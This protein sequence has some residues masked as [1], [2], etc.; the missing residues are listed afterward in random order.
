MDAAWLGVRMVETKPCSVPVGPREAVGQ[1]TKDAVTVDNRDMW[2]SLRIKRFGVY[3]ILS[4]LSGERGTPDAGER[5]RVD[6]SWPQDEYSPRVFRCLHVSKR[7]ADPGATGPLGSVHVL[8]F[9]FF[10]FFL[11]FCV[12]VVR[13]RVCRIYAVH[14][15]GRSLFV[16][17]VEKRPTGGHPLSKVQCFF[18]VGV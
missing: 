10:F 8:V 1:F 9:L 4:Y 11:F 18:C 17:F 7:S 15:L 13:A 12:V 3:L 16:R 6:D 14:L 2:T 5:S